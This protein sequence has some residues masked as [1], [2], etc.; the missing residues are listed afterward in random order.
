MIVMATR[1]IKDYNV[2]FIEHYRTLGAY[3]EIVLNGLGESE[4]GEVILKSF[5]SGVH[6]ISPQIVKVI[7]VSF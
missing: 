1:P 2:S 3:E 4:I 5:D 6:K 7:Q